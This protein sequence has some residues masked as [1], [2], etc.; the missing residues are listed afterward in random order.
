[1][2]GRTTAV[3]CLLHPPGMPII[4]PDSRFAQSVRPIIHH[5]QTFAGRA[6]MLPGFESEMQ[7][8]TA[9]THSNGQ[10]YHVTEMT[11]RPPTHAA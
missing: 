6:D 8:V 3:L 1:M 2:T 10:R 11:S 4:V 5:L 9:G 7:G